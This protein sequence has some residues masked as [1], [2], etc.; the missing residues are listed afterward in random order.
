[1]I[2]IRYIY[3]YEEPYNNV[4]NTGEYNFALTNI[5]SKEIDNEPY[6]YIE[7]IGT[8]NLIKLKCSNNIY[9]SVIVDENVLYLIEYRTDLFNSK[10]GVISHLDSENYIDKM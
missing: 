3:S 6:L 8:N 1:M 4:I 9:T 10:S 7:N 5:V 2:L